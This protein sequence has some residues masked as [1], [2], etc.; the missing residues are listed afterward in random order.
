MVKAKEKKPGK[1]RKPIYSI[2]FVPDAEPIREYSWKTKGNIATFKTEEDAYKH[3]LLEHFTTW[4]GRERSL[5]ILLL[6]SELSKLDPD[7]AY[8]IFL[9][10]DKQVKVFNHVTVM[11]Y[12]TK[13]KMFKVAFKAYCDMVAIMGLGDKKEK[14]RVCFEHYELI[15]H[16]AGTD[17][18][19]LG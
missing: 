6:V 16:P 5:Q 9:N 10:E 15:E 17:I 1:T 3:L 2:L 12:F 8:K 18:S 4:L 14:G 19:K 13:N 11:G 7:I